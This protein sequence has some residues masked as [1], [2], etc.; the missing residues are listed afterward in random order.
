MIEKDS[1]SF[2]VSLVQYTQDKT[3]LANQKPGGKVN[4][5]TD[6][7]GRYVEQFTKEAVQE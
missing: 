4:L 6:I 7:I 3:T 2:S 5:E 1:E